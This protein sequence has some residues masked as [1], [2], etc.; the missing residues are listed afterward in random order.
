MGFTSIDGVTVKENRLT[1][2]SIC[3]GTMVGSYDY[4]VDRPKEKNDLHG[5]GAFVMMC[6]ECSRAYSK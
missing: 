3:I 6:E 2:P 1:L 4:Y 5:I